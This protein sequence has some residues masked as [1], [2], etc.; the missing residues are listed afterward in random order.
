MGRGDGDVFVVEFEARV[1][2]R[3][4]WREVVRLVRCLAETLVRYAVGLRVNFEM[5]GCFFEGFVPL[6]L[7]FKLQ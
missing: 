3:R 1:A 4:P 5:L 6:M 2:L 7:G